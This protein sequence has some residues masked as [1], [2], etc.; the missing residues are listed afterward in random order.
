MTIMADHTSAP[1]PT[2]EFSELEVTCINTI[3]TLA[4]DAVRRPTPAPPA[5]RRAPPRVAYGLWTRSLNYAPPAPPWPTRARFV[6][7]NGP[8]S[9]PLSPLTHL[10]GVKN[11]DH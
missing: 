10:P 9:M 3:R 4:M 8:A 7:S 11:V 2:A 6:L 1:K 5:A